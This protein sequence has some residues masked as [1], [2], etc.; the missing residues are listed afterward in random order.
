ML[1]FG[2]QI[3]TSMME[4]MGLPK[5]LEAAAVKVDELLKW[6]KSYKVD[7]IELSIGGTIKSGSVTSLLLAAEGTGGIK[8][9]L[10][11]K[12]V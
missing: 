1:V 5:T 11:P 12:K 8:V 10:K 7:S 6:F 9:V 2:K 3:D 4:A